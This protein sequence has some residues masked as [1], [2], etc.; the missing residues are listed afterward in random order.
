MEGTTDLISTFAE[1]KNL[2]NIDKATMTGVLESV[3][4]DQLKKMYGDTASFDII[5]NIDKG[6]FELWRKRTVAET[7]VD[8]SK[9]ISLE[10]VHKIDDS[11]E[12]GEEY[13]ERVPIE[14]FGRRGILSIRQNLSG[15]IMDIEKAKLFDKYKELI[16]TVVVGEAYQVWKR[17]VLVMDEAG[18]ELSLPKSE[19]IPSDYFRKGDTVKAIV[20]SVE[21]RNNNTI[22]ILSRTSPEFL[23]KLFEEEVPEIFDGLITIKKVVRIPGERA[24][25]AVE[26]YD[27]RIDPVGACVGVKGSRI[28]GIV[29][30]LRNENI[31][32]IQWTNNTELL[33]RR[34][35]S[36][37]KISTVQI[38]DAT[39]HVMVFLKPS[40]V[41]LA[42]GKGGA[43][44]RLA[45][46][47]AG[48]EVD[49]Y[50]E[51]EDENQEEDVLLSEFTDEI[52][53]WIIE[54]LE[55]IGCD[56]AKS[57]LALSTEDIMQRAD[58]E[59]ETVEEVQKILRAEFE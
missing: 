14:S 13:S 34:A 18:N 5:I 25:V 1:F 19:Q 49:V 4:L 44:I 6:D 29:R 38:D 48:Y 16:G 58:L 39:K 56:T 12:V 15:R 27:E 52:D 20:S 30:E 36:P 43:N 57:V 46:Q 31:D 7:V 11:F 45:G 54:A 35:L 17:E 47:L 21:M 40:E 22:I 51:A 24:K 8:P 3:F 53:S 28:H 32:V 41:S 10:D 37:A 33:I 59:R 9:E 50:R 23:E 26:S 55:K 2:K 42:I